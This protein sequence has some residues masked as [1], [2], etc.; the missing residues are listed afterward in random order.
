MAVAHSGNMSN[1]IQFEEHDGVNNAKRVNIVAGSS[2]QATV[3]PQGL[4][5]L[6]PSPNFIGIVTVANPGASGNVTLDPGSRTGILGNLT[7]SDSKGFIGLVSIAGNVGINGNVTLS[8]SKGFIGL[9]TTTLG[10]SPAFVGIVTIANSNVRS[11][12]GN[13]TLSDAKTFIGLTT[14]TLGA[15]PAFIGIATTINAASPAFIG[16][17]TVAGISTLTLSDPKGYIGLITVGGIGTVT[18]ADPKGFIGLVTV[19][20]SYLDTFASLGTL[21]ISLASIASSTTGVG[22]QSTLVDNTSNKYTS[23][24]VYLKLETGG[25]APTANSLIYVYL[26]RYD[27]NTVADDGAGTSDAALTVV[28]APLLGTILVS[29]TGTN[30]FYYGCFDTSFLG[31]LG[32]KWGIAIVNSSG[33]ALHGTEGNMLKNWIGRNLQLT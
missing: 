26:V 20:A 16:I 6:A 22:R 7:L 21:T 12:A 1:Q 33:A 27:N 19:K 2:G 15:S 29:T 4:V 13:V 3:T 8:D 31:P 24:M 14:T 5:T 17:V 23:A 9:T 28:N 25:S 30:T 32:P 11:I 10:A 18:L